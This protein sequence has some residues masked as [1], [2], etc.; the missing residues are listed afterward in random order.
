LLLLTACL[1]TGI[2]LTSILMP[3]RTNILV[4]GLDSR[5]PGSNLG[6]S[7]TMIL[8]TVLPREPY[9][10]MLSIPRDLWVTIP[11]VG[12]NRINAAHYFAE[13][14]Q[15][16]SGPAAAVETVVLNFGVNV[17]YYIRLRFDGFQGVVDALD[18]VDVNLPRPMSGYPA[19]THH[20]DGEAALALVRDRAGSD[21]FFRMERGQIFLKALM[22]R[23]LSPTIWP[24]LPKTLSL[25]SEMVDTNI[26]PWLWIRFGLTALRVGSDNIDAR[27]ITREMVDPFTTSAGAQV[28]APDW[29]MINPVLLEMFGQE[30][31]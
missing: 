8:A 27:S 13:A 16:G 3:S 17:D 30:L 11:G 24:R 15:P 5:E 31:P 2:L 10:G 26:P 28:L 7:D 14:E 21:D 22:K 6:R 20:L 18:G 23:L 29:A 9:I 1:V 12:E 4:L 25:L 19:G